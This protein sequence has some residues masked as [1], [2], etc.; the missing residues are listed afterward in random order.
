MSTARPD[1]WLSSLV[2]LCIVMRM[3]GSTLNQ[4]V[5]TN[6]SSMIGGY[7][8]KQIDIGRRQLLVEGLALHGHTSLRLRAAPVHRAFPPDLH[9]IVVH[10]DFKH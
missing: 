3:L 6:P 10:C 5:S 1:G 2:L 4:T 7:G 8:R 9:S